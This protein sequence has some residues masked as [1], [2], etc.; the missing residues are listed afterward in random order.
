MIYVTIAE[1]V[2]AVSH[3][4]RYPVSIKECRYS[5]YIVEGRSID[6][7]TIEYSRRP[8][9]NTAEYKFQEVK[10]DHYRKVVLEER[11]RKNHE[12]NNYYISFILRHTSV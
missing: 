4:K 9:V 10:K 8:C 2:E 1:S 12:N 11:E 7:E 6:K 3:V 5:F